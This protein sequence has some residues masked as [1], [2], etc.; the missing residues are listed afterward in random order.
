MKENE[1][2]MAVRH[3]VHGSFI[4]RMEDGEVTG[5]RIFCDLG[6]VSVNY[7]FLWF[8]HGERGERFASAVRDVVSAKKEG[9]LMEISEDR[10][11]EDHICQ[12]CGNLSGNSCRLEDGKGC[13]T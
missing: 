4:R 12:A 2:I 5:M 7:P 10:K 9:R 1:V 8:G 13:S 11:A 3:H 6:V